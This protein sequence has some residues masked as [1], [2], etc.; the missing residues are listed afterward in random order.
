MTWKIEIV[1][2]GPYELD[3]DL[4]APALGASLVEHLKAK[5]VTVASATFTAGQY[6]HDI[7]DAE[8]YDAFVK[9][10]IDANAKAHAAMLA[11]QPAPAEE[12]EPVPVP[13]AP[14]TKPESPEPAK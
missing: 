9:G 2:E 4:S 10:R 8:K 6:G 11:T 7:S 13:A 1:G 5:G 14:E 3:A 12:P